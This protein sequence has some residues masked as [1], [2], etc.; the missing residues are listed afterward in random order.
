MR[1]RLILALTAAIAILLWAEGV[2]AEGGAY[3]PLAGGLRSPAGCADFVNWS[4][5]TVSPRLRRYELIAGAA[6]RIE[7]CQPDHSV[8]WPV[9]SDTG[10]PWLV[11]PATG[12]ALEQS[13]LVYTTAKGRKAEISQ[14]A[15]R[16]GLAEAKLEP[17]P[18]GC[19]VDHHWAEGYSLGEARMLYA[20]NGVRYDAEPCA[21]REPR[22]SYKH[23]AVA[24]PPLS[25]QGGPL[26]LVSLAQ[27]RVDIAVDGT[28]RTILGC[29][30]IAGNP[31]NLEMRACPGKLFHDIENRQSLG[32]RRYVLV[33]YDRAR[34][35]TETIDATNCVPDPNVVY[36]HDDQ[37]VA[38]EHDADRGM[39]WPLV[40]TVAVPMS[41]AAQEAAGAGAARAG[42]ALIVVA[43]KHRAGQPVFWRPVQFAQVP[44][45]ETE[46]LGCL[47]F[48]L[49]D[50]VA[51]YLR[52]DNQTVRRVLGP[53]EPVAASR[54][55]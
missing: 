42:N 32:A 37:I 45:G 14:C 50:S 39:S 25:V 9:S 4:A 16:Q 17:S 21:R 3:A 49:M 48:Q 2:N 40:Q 19:R 41:S 1:I 12:R 34:D 38:W 29:Q 43:A 7:G 18:F 51:D 44:T 23:Q 52:P 28:P 35:T 22:Q 30:P 33:V 27:R 53:S 24:C 20:V 15:P 10:C 31:A 36:G 54:C 55:R 47:Q 46:T 26:G 5:G 11:S 6:Q 13:R 8:A